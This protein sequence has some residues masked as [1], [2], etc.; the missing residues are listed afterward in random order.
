MDSLEPDPVFEVNHNFSVVSAR[1]FYA[2]SRSKDKTFIISA[3]ADKTMKVINMKG[4][5]KAWTDSKESYSAMSPL[6][7]STNFDRV[8]VKTDN[9]I[10]AGTIKPELQFYTV[11]EETLSIIPYAKSK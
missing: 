4:E 7:K 10:V 6:R 3:S 5:E 11:D 8:D 2:P 9:I 1:F